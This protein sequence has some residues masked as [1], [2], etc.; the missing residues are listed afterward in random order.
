MAHPLSFAPICSFK[1]S[2]TPGALTVT[3]NS[4]VSA[5]I[6]INEACHDSKARNFQSLKVKAADDNPSTK[7]KSIVCSDCEGNGAILC[8]QCK[9]TGVNSVDHFNGQ[10]KAGGLCWLCRE[11]SQLCFVLWLQVWILLI[12]GHATFVK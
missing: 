6:R 12:K 11:P 3:G 1:S 7:T 5:F 2:S 8:T 10:F 9:G 4:V